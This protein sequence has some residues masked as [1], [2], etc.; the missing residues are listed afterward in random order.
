[1]DALGRVM[2]DSLKGYES[3]RNYEKIFTCQR[4]AKI[5]KISIKGLVLSNI[6][7][8]KKYE[9]IYE[10]TKKKAKIRKTNSRKFQYLNPPPNR[11]KASVKRQN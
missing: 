3:L 10:S 9:K 8:A 7:N 2:A 11:E 4:Q 6:K 5:R 1:M